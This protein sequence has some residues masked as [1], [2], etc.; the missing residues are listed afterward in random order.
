MSYLL[1]H[2]HRYVF[3]PVACAHLRQAGTLPSVAPA[4]VGEPSHAGAVLCSGWAVDQAI[5][6]E[7]DRLVVV[8]ECPSPLCATVQI[9]CSPAG[10]TPAKAQLG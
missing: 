1:P 8:R 3:P 2:L 9:P 5:M 7:E 4:E 10:I 6:S